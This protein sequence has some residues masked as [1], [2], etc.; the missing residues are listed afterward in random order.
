MNEEAKLL[1]G[2]IPLRYLNLSVRTMNPLLGEDG[3]VVVDDVRRLTDA[4]LLCIPNF[5]RKAL[6]ELRAAIGPHVDVPELPPVQ[7]VVNKEPP[8][9]HLTWQPQTG[10]WRDNLGNDFNLWRVNR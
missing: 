1:N 5:G 4:E 6:R 7:T 9:V 3:L 2:S 10:L 8:S